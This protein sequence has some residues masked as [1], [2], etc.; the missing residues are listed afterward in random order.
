MFSAREFVE[1]GSGPGG[2]HGAGVA[3]AGEKRCRMKG[4]GGKAL[5]G[6]WWVCRC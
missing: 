5:V 6:G 4:Q 2:E 3:A 1:N